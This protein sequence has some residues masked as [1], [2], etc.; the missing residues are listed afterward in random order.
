MEGSDTQTAPEAAQVIVNLA[1][2][3]MGAKKITGERREKEIG[4]EK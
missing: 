1:H 3:K 2:I 4:R